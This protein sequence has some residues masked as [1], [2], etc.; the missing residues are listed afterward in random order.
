MKLDNNLP[1]N[2]LED[3][4]DKLSKKLYIDSPDLWIDFKDKIN[5]HIFDEMV[6]FFAC[7]YNFI[8]II[9]HAIGNKI[10]N[11][12]LPS[13]N[14]SYPNVI[15]HLI[16]VAMQNNNLDICNYL[17]NL[18]IKNNNLLDCINIKNNFKKENIYIEGTKEKVH[19]GKTKNH[20]PNFEC[21]KCHSNIFESGFSVCETV[22]Y[23]YSDKIKSTIETSRKILNPVTCC[24]CNTVL[25]EV[26]VE[27][28]NNL[29]I[30]QNCGKCSTDLTTCGIVDKAK[31]VFN[32]ET[33]KFTPSSTSYH[34]ANCDN[35]ITENQQ[36]YFGL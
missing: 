20:V 25:K 26:T 35:L 9:K 30:V 14:I 23:K 13:K 6:L 22:E 34:C 12:D 21:S 27:K 29:C 15:D 1:V 4:I 3:D 7:K 17:K 31:M 2:T 28:L 32:S 33:N 36:N 11:L 19:T 10:V 16:S 5:S 18:P 8:S 24:N